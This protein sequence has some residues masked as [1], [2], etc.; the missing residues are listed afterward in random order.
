MNE[1][2]KP[3]RIARR[4]RAAPL[5]LVAALLLARAAWALGELQQKPGTAGCVSETGTGG[6]RFRRRGRSRPGK[7]IVRASSYCLSAARLASAFADGKRSVEQALA[8]LLKH[9]RHRLGALEA[10]IAEQGAEGRTTFGGQSG[11]SAVS[12]ETYPE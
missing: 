1:T 9:H 7:H 12:K 6:S 2:I 10:A 8:G 3:T 5:A 11:V 4:R